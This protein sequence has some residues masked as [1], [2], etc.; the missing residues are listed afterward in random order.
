VVEDVEGVQTDRGGRSLVFR[1]GQVEI[2]S[3]PQVQLRKS[4]TLQAVSRYSYRTIIC[5]TIAIR[6][7]ACRLAVWPPGI[8]RQPDA[9]V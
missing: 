7:L 3:P 6:I 1:M 5:Q 9:Q 8:Q 2:S 4:G